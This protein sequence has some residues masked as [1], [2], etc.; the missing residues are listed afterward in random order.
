MPALQSSTLIA[1]PP[2]TVAG[3]LRDSE[4]AEEALARAGHGLTTPARLLAVDDEVQLDAR[5]GPGL[6]IGLSTRI[7]AISPAGMTSVLV[8]GPVRELEHVTSLSP[9]PGGTLVCDQIRWY[10]RCG[11]L[12][13]IADA[14][15]VHPLVRRLLAARAAVLTQR[16]AALVVTPVVVATALVRNGRVLAAQRSRPAAL[17]GRWELP[18][19]RVEPGESE[20]D[21]VV[22]ECREEL[23]TLVRPDGR[24]GTDL[25]IDVGVLRV[26]RAAPVP[27]A[28]EPR[29]LEHRDVRWVGPHELAD[30][31]WVDADRAVLD[32]VAA[33]LTSR[34]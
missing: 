5:L 22:R 1:A 6:R 19:G 30:L 16:A 12:G 21:A 31:D 2:R 8:R 26:H 15:I 18:G 17:A 7:V 14:A 3:W 10:P 11:A 4:V 23:G 13:R 29:P 24:L 20:T 32:D 33:E 28:P 34:S 27:G 25:P 9:A